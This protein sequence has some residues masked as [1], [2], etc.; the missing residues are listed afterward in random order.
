MISTA[1]QKKQISSQ[2]GVNIFV[3]SAAVL[4]CSVALSDSALSKETVNKQS[5]TKAL[6]TKLSAI[7][8]T[9]EKGI[10]VFENQHNQ[11]LVNLNNGKWSV[12]N[13]TDNSWCFKDADFRV[14]QTA[15]NWQEPQIKIE[16]GVKAYHSKFGEGKELTVTYT[17]EQGYDPCRKLI[18]RLYQKQSFIEVAWGIKNRFEYPVKVA[19]IDLVSR[20]Q[21]FEGQTVEKP[22]VLRSGSG[23]E[24]N[25]IE[26]KWEINALNGAM[27]TYLDSGKRRT[28]V[29]AGLKYNEFG[30][31]VELK[32]HRGFKHMNLQVWD[33][34]G[35]Q[36]D[37]GKTY[38]SQD[39]VYLDFTTKDP[40]KS[41]ESYGLA[42]RE[43]NAANPNVYNFPSL[44][45]WMISTTRFGEGLAIN[46]SVDMI[47][48]AK[49][50]KDRG[51]TKYAPLAV[52]LEPDFYGPGD[53]GNTQQGWWDDEHWRKYG[54]GGM[55]GPEK[56]SMIGTGK[57]SL[58]KPY[59]TFAKFS[60]GVHDLG[61][62]VLTYFQC[63]I[64]SLDFCRAHPEWMLN[65]DI[66]RL[67]L[68]HRLN[69]SYVKYDYSDPGFREYML[70]T[71]KRLKNEGLDGV[72]FDYP[73][74]SW[75][76]TGGFEDKT[77]TT[78]SVYRELFR[79]CREGLG[80]KAYIHERQLGV[81]G[82]PQQDLSAGIVDLQRVWYDA[83]H[84][85]PEMATRMGLRWYKSRSV[86]LYYPDGKTFHNR[87]KEI[88]QYM[89]RAFL[90]AIGFIAGRLEIGTSVG[91][92]TDEML[93]DTS[94]LYPM[95][96][97]TQS[98]R[99]VDMLLGKTHP[100]T[101]VYQVDK[102]WHQ[103]M[104][105]NYNSKKSETI[106]APLSGDT[107]ST[108]SL[109][110]DADAEYHAFDF[111]SQKYL[112]KLQGTDKLSMELRVGEVA[113]ISVRKVAT[114]PQ[115]VSTNR[116]FMQGMM[117]C[118][119][120][121]WA[122]STLSGKVDVVEDDELVLTVAGNGLTPKSCEGATIRPRTDGLIDLVFKTTK[123]ETKAF[124]V[125]FK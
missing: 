22:M 115:I 85:E 122:G 60:K 44:C 29:V 101:Y 94:R 82:I 1:S 14:D 109:G 102:N 2:L 19:N 98:P 42:M 111:W 87:G 17:P 70:K 62:T 118:H 90:T 124:K 36:I 45:G 123:S 4:M 52:R 99:P 78:S 65:N 96:G 67:H 56:R 100:E 105:A 16:W 120:I 95:F 8:A 7:H 27:L 28:M 93:H 84:F 69:L 108:G 125:I 35:K 103:V 49:L 114:H 12:K 61:C 54:P 73:E 80:E 75:I 121:K 13:R 24:M 81:G 79:L 6:T 113:M 64:P 51:F 43:A 23:A 40:F 112:G 55:R 18:L 34:Q 86:F 71:W 50:A 116:H 9:E 15:H 117:E 57:G 107:I 47:G 38:I 21:L 25:R 74:S 110:L 66:S 48:Q 32:N 88:P 10:I 63:N 11:I 77:F 83:N 39:S 5:D 46:N 91:K 3:K 72:K 41:L 89:Q 26:N 97:G 76:A 92:M 104:L 31:K 53:F 59:D 37:P 20:G 119:D 68:D 58:R 33:P 106:S 30:R